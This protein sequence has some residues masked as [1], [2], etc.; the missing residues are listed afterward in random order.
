MSCQR[1]TSG[2]V[3]SWRKWVWSRPGIR[4]LESVNLHLSS[5][6]QSLQQMDW[7]ETGMLEE[8]AYV[9]DADRTPYLQ[10]WNPLPHPAAL[11]LPF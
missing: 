10:L 7:Q 5:G 9:T 8:M 2:A 1:K 11:G 3:T 6:H 4:S